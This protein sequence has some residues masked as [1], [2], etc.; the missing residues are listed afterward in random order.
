MAVMM[1]DLLLDSSVTKTIYLFNGALV[2]KKDA[3]KY[4]KHFTKT[5]QVTPSLHLFFAQQVLFPVI[6]SHNSQNDFKY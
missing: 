4:K 3:N 6:L 5:T 2:P 1:T